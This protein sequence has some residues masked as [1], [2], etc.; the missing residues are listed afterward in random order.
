MS[1]GTNRERIEQNNLKLED[2]KTQVQNLPEYQD[3]SD[4][5]ATSDDILS[6]K[7]AY[8]NGE[9]IEGNIPEYSSI[10]TSISAIIGANPV[11]INQFVQTYNGVSYNLISFNDIMNDRGL[12]NVGSNISLCVLPSELANAIGL[13]ADK[14]KKGETILGITGTFEATA[15]VQEQVETLTQENEVLTTTVD[16]ATEKADNLLGGAE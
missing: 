16:T 2:I 13:T 3:T 4:A 1:T 11:T 14:I 5:N 6:G 8:V 15:E 7:T 10:D 9:K 12:L